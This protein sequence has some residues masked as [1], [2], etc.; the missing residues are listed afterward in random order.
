MARSHEIDYKIF[1]D[2]LQF[3]EVELD[4]NETV[5]AE[6]GVMMYMEEGID[7]QAKM[8]DG[9]NPSTGFFGSLMN[10]G[11]RVFTG[12]SIFLTHLRIMVMV[13]NTWPLVRPIQV[14]S[15]GSTWTWQA[16]NCSAKKI[17]SWLLL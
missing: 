12:E 1:G 5:I 2:D 13:N 15:L 11:K 16:V 10:V 8:G 17:H 7:F 6:A 4:P 9:S 14:R 3:V